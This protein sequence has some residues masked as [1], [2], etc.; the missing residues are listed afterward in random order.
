MKNATSLLLLLIFMNACGSE[1]D[2]APVVVITHE[3]QI[4]EPTGCETTLNCF[5]HCDDN[6]SCIERCINNEDST[7]SSKAVGVAICL[8]VARDS[9]FTDECRLSACSN[10]IDICVGEVEYSCGQVIDCQERCLDSDCESRCTDLASQQAKQEMDDI[11]VCFG[12][13]SDDAECIDR[14]CWDEISI[15]RQ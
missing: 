13:C 8:D 1:L 10:Y 12:E 15:C 7:E 14:R 11:F 9:C 5:A 4:H 6:A 3:S 2:E